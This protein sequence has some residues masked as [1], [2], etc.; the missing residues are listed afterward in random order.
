MLPLRPC[1]VKIVGR[2]AESVRAQKREEGV[3]EMGLPEQV[4]DGCV[5]ER[6][7]L[8]GEQLDGLLGDY[9]SEVRR[10]R[11]Q[12]GRTCSHTD[13]GAKGRRSAF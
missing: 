5:I 13:I 11:W 4:D 2:G 8:G 6:D 12:V 10:C 1:G 9:A 3:T 7:V